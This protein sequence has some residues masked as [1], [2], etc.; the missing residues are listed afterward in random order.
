MNAMNFV[1]SFIYKVQDGQQKP[2]T[3]MKTTFNTMAGGIPLNER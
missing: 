3:H 1:Q 2:T